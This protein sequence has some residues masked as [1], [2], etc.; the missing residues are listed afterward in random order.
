MR[1]QIN[2]RRI[3]VLV[4]IF[5]LIFIASVGLSTLGLKLP[6]LRQFFAFIYLTFIPGIL[7]LN[8][9]SLGKNLVKIIL[10]SS[11]LS[12]S[13][14]MFVGLIIN[15]L[16]F[17]ANPPLSEIP[18]IA[19]VVT[20]V[21]ILC[22]LNLRNRDFSLSVSIDADIKSL[23]LQ[24]LL[25]IL[26]ILGSLSIRTYNTDFLLLVFLLVVSIIPLFVALNVVKNT[27]TFLFCVSFS[28]LITE[29]IFFPHIFGD[30]H[31]EYYFAKITL[32]NNKWDPAFPHN[33]NTLLSTTIL[34]LFYSIFGDISL[35][36]VYKIVMVFIYSLAFPTLY[37]ICRELSLGGKE[38]F[39]SSF[40][41]LCLPMS[42]YYTVSAVRQEVALLFMGL[43]LLSQ[44]DKE[45]TNRQRWILG[46]IFLLSL[47]V[48][49]YGTSY[50]F[51]FSLL[52]SLLY[53]ILSKFLGI[54]TESRVHPSLFV[55]AMVSILAWHIYIGRSTVFEE[56]TSIIKQIMDNLE[57]LLNPEYAHG[58]SYIFREYRTF[59]RVFT[60]L[61]FTS[62][63]IILL[64]LFEEVRRKYRGNKSY[65][66]DV[67]FGISIGAVIILLASIV[68]PRF[69]GYTSIDFPRLHS[70]MTY[71]LAP[72]FW[73][74]G[75]TISALA[76]KLFNIFPREKV[77][78]IL[79]AGFLTLYFLFG[80]GFAFKFQEESPNLAVL[81]I[82]AQQDKS[83]EEKARLYALYFTDKD[84][85]G[86]KWVSKFK[87]EGMKVYAG[88]YPASSL[89]V[90]Y[91]N[92]Y[93]PW[94]RYVEAESIPIEN[95]A[96]EIEK[97]SLLFVTEF[98]NKEGYM[99]KRLPVKTVNDTIDLGK[100]LS[101]NT[102]NIVYSNGGV[103]IY[104]VTG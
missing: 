55:L 88:H 28:L 6:L 71:I 16:D 32:E 7:I 56:V 42:I 80:S 75:V 60:S 73:L 66:N 25:F 49:H 86:A 14:I 44:V 74:G 77:A 13:L 78:S 2:N 69:S 89:L 99:L 59:E 65:V 68:I 21:L 45:I 54:K 96:Q 23:L 104:Y 58:A 47:I 12:I 64:G 100:L 46:V 84:I 31:Y 57:E 97:S 90:S 18:L 63:I 103:T 62:F 4:A 33:A 40:L 67:Y 8:L 94:F 22:L 87:P 17:L 27:T 82:Y 51:T 48:S 98:E 79:L 101:N 61:T 35:E 34:P 15:S 102:E 20:L 85:S 24:C 76:R 19:S 50:L 37:Q 43:F 83:L 41:P 92:L 29:Q 1:I 93:S 81:L 3:L 10:Y 53:P 38:S 39:L 26:A 91:G 72:F 95:E 5:Q 9:F 52:I 70:I 30:S 36:T 11:G